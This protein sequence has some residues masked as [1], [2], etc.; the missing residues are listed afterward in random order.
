[1]SNYA[2][3]TRRQAAGA[4]EA[5]PSSR[6]AREQVQGLSRRQLLRGSLGAAVGLWL[7]EVTRRAR[8]ASCGRNL[9][10]RL[11][12][13]RSGSATSTRSRTPTPACRS[14]RAFPRTSRRRARSS[15]LIDTGRQQFFPGRRH[16]RRHGPQRPRPLP[17]LPA[18]RLQT[19]SVPPQLLARVPVPRIALRPARHQGRRCAVRP[20]AAEHGPLLAQRRQRWR[21]DDRYRPD[22]PRARCP[23]PSVS[24]ASSRRVRRPAA[25]DRDP[26]RG[27]D[28]RSTRPASR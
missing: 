24:P 13:A 17:A 4:H 22:H 16:R 25:S 7:L 26:A 21:A 8:S 11:S 18:P 12:A 6:A 2:R 28:D 27:R 14:T 10:R 1:M 15:P 23:S 5:R 19:E 3:R 20:G 9:A